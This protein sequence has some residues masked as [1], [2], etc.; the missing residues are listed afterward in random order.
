MI[1]NVM[2]LRTGN[3][4]VYSCAPRE[5]VVCAYEQDRRNWNTWTYNFSIAR[6]G[7]SGL[8]VSCGDFSAMLYQG[9]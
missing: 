3:Y 9:R 5:A 7:P 8:T 2:D 6:I 4:T 1:T